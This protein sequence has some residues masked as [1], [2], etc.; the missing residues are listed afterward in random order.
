[1]RCIEPESAVFH[2]I[3]GHQGQIYTIV[4]N[5]FLTWGFYPERD[6]LPGAMYNLRCYFATCS[7]QGQTLP[8]LPAKRG[9][10]I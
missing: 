2:S 1:M 9:A 8:A 3:T 5:E 4:F 10:C 6:E 7:A